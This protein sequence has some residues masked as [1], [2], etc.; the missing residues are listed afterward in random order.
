MRTQ[1]FFKALFCIFIIVLLVYLFSSCSEKP[2]KHPTR[3]DCKPTGQSR[4][5][6]SGK[7]EWK[8]V[9]GEGELQGLWE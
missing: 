5:G 1:D 2:P 7:K 3:P 8:Y 9:C 4:I 6:K